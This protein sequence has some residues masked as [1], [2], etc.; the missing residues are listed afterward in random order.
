M[1]RLAALVMVVGLLPSIALAQEAAITGVV[2]DASGA[3]LP[4]VTVEASSGALT[5]KVRAVALTTRGNIASS[6][7]RPATTRSRSC[8]PVSAP[9]SGKG[10]N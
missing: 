5:E 8:F 9:S 2:T 1:P 4:G 7:S 3:V 6:R 10:F